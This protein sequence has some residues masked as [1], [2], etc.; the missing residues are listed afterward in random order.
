[1]ILNFT[2][3]KELY[4]QIDDY[5][6]QKPKVVAASS[7]AKPR[8]VNNFHKAGIP[9][10]L[11]PVDILPKQRLIDV[12]QTLNTQEN[13]NWYYARRSI[14]VGHNDNKILI[15]KK[16]IGIGLLFGLIQ[17]P[18]LQFFLILSVFAI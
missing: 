14:Y 5:D 9:E 1:M 10:Q 13:D 15:T 8:K 18:I 3:P 11:I 16:P 6:V 2:V 4:S 17:R 12:I 7:T